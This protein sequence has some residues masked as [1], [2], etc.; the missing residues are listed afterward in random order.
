MP[1]PVTALPHAS[2]QYSSNILQQGPEKDYLKVNTFL[3][4]FLKL[5]S[6]QYNFLSFHSL[7]HIY[8]GMLNFANYAT[9]V[10]LDNLSSLEVINMIIAMT[11]T[12]SYNKIT[13][14]QLHIGF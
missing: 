4:L 13:S 12:I 1:K 8:Y 11:V 2:P 3:S 7:L 5:K 9:A 6:F 10:C 14:L